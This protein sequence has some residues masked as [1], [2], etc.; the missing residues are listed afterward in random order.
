[1]RLLSVYN[2]A[3]WLLRH[4][5]LPLSLLLL[6]L[7][8]LLLLMLLLLGLLLLLPL[9]PG[10]CGGCATACSCW[11]VGR[12]ERQQAWRA[13][14]ES[15][16]QRGSKPTHDVHARSQGV[17]LRCRPAIPACQGVVAL[18]IIKQLREGPGRWCR[19]CWTRACRRGCRSCRG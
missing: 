7:P 9:P 19:R 1:M 10:R 11:I 8:L 3:R 17:G 6:L 12:T 13:L 4:R 16:P 18:V 15:K 2:Q 5:W 14:H